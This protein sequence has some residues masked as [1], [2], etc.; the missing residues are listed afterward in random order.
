[1]PFGSVLLVPGV[2]VERT[3]TL[4]QA[5]YSQSSFGRFKDGLFQKLGG[6]EKFF[7]NTVGGTPR[8]LHAWQD[9]NGT[10]QLAVGT[11]TE[12]GVIADDALT[13]ITPQ[14]K[15]TNPTLSFSTTTGSATITIVDTNIANVTIYDSIY[16]NTPVSAGGII[17]SGLYPIASIGGSTSYTITAADAAVSAVSTGGA[18]PIFTTTTASPVVSVGFP[19]HGQSVGDISVFP[20]STSV[21]GTSVSGSYTDT[22][23]ADANN[24]SITTAQQAS[25]ATTASM[26]GGAAQIV[27]YVT[28]GP[29]AGGVGFGVGAFGVGGFGSGVVPTGQT[30]TAITASDWTL[31]NWGKLAMACPKNGGIYFWDPNGGFQNASLVSSG[32]IFNSGIFV[33]MTTQILVAYGS[34]VTEGIGVQQDPMLIK[35]SD[36]GNFLEWDQNSETQAR[37]F[38]IPIGSMIVGGMPIS[39]KNLIW[40]DLDLWA[41]TYV[42]PPNVFGFDKIGAGAGLAGAHAAGQLRGNVYW[43]GQSNFYVLSGN[44]VQVIPCPVWDVVF[45]DLDTDNLAKIRAAPNTPFNEMWWFYPSLSG[46]TGECDK[47][48]KV[49]ITEPGQPWDYGSLPRSAWID[50]SVLGPPIGASPQS[51]VYQHETTNNADGSPLSSSFTTGYFYLAEGEDFA[52]IDQIIPDMKWGTYAGSQTAQVQLTFNVIDYPGDT[53][54][55]YGPYAITQSTE[56][57]STRFRGRQ[58]SITAQS[59]DLGSFWRL[60]KIRYRWAPDGRR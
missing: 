49:N 27:Y 23:V 26:N 16:L 7:A 46:G 6:W 47:Y 21:G 31:D 48:V 9:L 17:L 44:G 54:R 53:P 22:S 40:T 42:G 57:I 29:P 52:F 58:M 37:E 28:L 33:S 32:P 19:S 60:G 2:N 11:T 55:T 56:Y 45:Q 3:P 18:V 34:T 5:G 25:S 59:D 51:I 14:T 20:I 30:G 1:M 39:L 15:T 4:L 36:E 8:A 24:F 50:Q 12:L 38:R 10:D 43:M 41:M 13:D 35:W